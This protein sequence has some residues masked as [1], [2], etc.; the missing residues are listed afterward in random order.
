MNADAEEEGK[1]GDGREEKAPPSTSRG[2]GFL[3]S[4]PPLLRP[5]EDESSWS[6]LGTE[7]NTKDW[8]SP[9]RWVWA[10]EGEGR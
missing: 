8:S 9:R 10:G 3:K 6:G 2:E 4:G 7:G 1:S 5:S